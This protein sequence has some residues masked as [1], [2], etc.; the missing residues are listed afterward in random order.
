MTEKKRKYNTRLI[1]QGCSYSTQDI[2]ALYGLHK[3]TVQMWY[4]EGLS[5]IDD[6]KPYLVMGRDLKEFLDKRQGNR[7]RHCKPNEFYC[8]KC[9]EP[10]TCWENAVDI[11]FQNEKRLLITGLCSQCETP[12]NKA[13]STK[14]L[15]EI[16]KIFMV[17]QMHH[18][19][20]TGFIPPVYNTDKIEEIAR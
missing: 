15:E 20:L 19:H 6:R 5:R 12:V 1:K 18:K 4:S 7:K 11:K 16:Q 3:R 17:Q 10:R 13:S 9:R 14:E 2:V 8:F